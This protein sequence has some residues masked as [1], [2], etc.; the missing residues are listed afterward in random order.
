MP[1]SAAASAGASLTPSPTIATTWPPS[2]SAVTRAALSP[3]NTSAITSSAV[4]PRRAAIASAAPRLSPEIMRSRK[5]EA[6]SRESASV[7]P[8]FGSSPK[9]KQANDAG[10]RSRCRITRGNGW[11]WWLPLT[12]VIRP[13]RSPSTDQRPSPASS[14]NCQSAM[15]CQQCGPRCR[16]RVSP[17][18][19]RSRHGHVAACGAPVPPHGPADAR[20]PLHCGDGG[21][22]LRLGPVVKVCVAVNCGCPTVRVPVL[23]KATVSTLCANS[24]ACVL[25]QNALPGGDPVPAMMAA[26]VA[27]PSAHW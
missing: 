16:G 19:A 23:S 3:G 24:S 14:A 13:A 12:A 2:R 25:D 1:A 6:R 20:C 7:A 15:P 26:G 17:N 4:S 8:G 18:V 10:Y 22:K 5:P 21:E 11:K 9:A 27:R